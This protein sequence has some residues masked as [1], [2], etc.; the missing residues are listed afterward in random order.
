M[1][2]LHR[3]LVQIREN[4]EFHELIQ[5]DK[6]TRPRCLLW[7]G[8]LPALSALGAPVSWAVGPG[9]VAANVL[10][11]RL[12]GYAPHVLD[13]WARSVEF[14]AGAGSGVLPADPDVWTDRSLVWDEVSGVSCG[15]AVFS[16]S[17][18]L[19]LVGSIGL[20]CIWICFPGDGIGAERSWLYLSVPKPLQIIQRAELWRVIA[21]LQAS[22]PVHLGVDNASVVGHVGRIIA[23]KLPAGT[24]ELLV[25]GDLLVPVKCL[26]KLVCLE[27]QPSPKSR[28]VRMKV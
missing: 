25:D 18:F 13:G 2:C 19:V 22:K 16:C 4:P 24:F 7:P 5:R 3:P 17:F 9:Q 11:S 15:G 10:E 20:G 12:G 6:R 28:V 8:W 21:A 26:L 14:V 1:E 23:G 27:L